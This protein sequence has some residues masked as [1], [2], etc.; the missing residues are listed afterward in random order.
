MKPKFNDSHKPKEVG[1]VEKQQDT[2]AG[3]VTRRAFTEASKLPPKE[4]VSTNIKRDIGEINYNNLT[5]WLA[6]QGKIIESTSQPSDNS[7]TEAFQEAYKDTE[8]KYYNI[9]IDK[10]R[11]DANKLISDYNDIKRTMQDTLKEELDRVVA[12][13]DHTHEDIYEKTKEVKN[14]FIYARLH[15]LNDASKALKL[16]IDDVNN[17]SYI[18]EQQSDISSQVKIT[19]LDEKLQRAESEQAFVKQES[20]QIFHDNPVLIPSYEKENTAVAQAACKVRDT[21]PLAPFSDQSDKSDPMTKENKKDI[22]NTENK[23]KRK[24][25][26]KIRKF[27]S[28][29]GRTIELNQSIPQG[30]SFS[31]KF[32]LS[33]FKKA[34]YSIDEK[35][36]VAP[37]S[38]DRNPLG[39]A[40]FGNKGRVQNGEA[41]ENIVQDNFASTKTPKKGDRVF[42]RDPSTKKIT[43]G[44]WVERVQNNRVSEISSQWHDGGGIYRHHPDLRKETFGD[45]EVYHQKKSPSDAFKQVGGKAN[46][47]EDAQ[48]VGILDQHINEKHPPAINELINSLADEGDIVLV[49]GAG[50]GWKIDQRKYKYTELV[51]KELN[52]FGW[53]N[54]EHHANAFKKQGEFQNLVKT[55]TDTKLIIQKSV[56]L[57]DVRVEKRN[58]SLMRTIYEAKEAFPDKR[59][60]FIAG[61]GHFKDDP[62]LQKNLDKPSHIVLKPLH[63]L[64]Q[65][66]SFKKGW[67]Q[68]EEES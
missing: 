62:T 25:D 64:L 68:V 22:S 30:P 53:D 13:P 7:T 27:V 24:S 9:R 52:V 39:Y 47:V 4:K 43:F 51:T 34:G 58:E 23:Q 21:H 17:L 50:V 3:S 55:S 31:I 46:C 38:Y 32:E 65:E 33:L 28:D 1:K 5:K 67:K 49:E 2:Q 45:W 16:H 60:F 48:V 42:Y 29:T 41:A 15:K 66:D 63:D 54:M 10:T 37:P 6:D 40:I 8:K 19:M 35:C 36:V 18:L 11:K 20:L 26:I 12:K 59:I 14:A 56:E 57:H 61:A 44:G